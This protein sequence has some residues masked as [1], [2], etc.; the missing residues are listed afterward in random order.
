V[1]T[2]TRGK[3]NDEGSREDH[4][5]PFAHPERTW[6]VRVH[7]CLHANQVSEGSP[8]GVVARAVCVV[9]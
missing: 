5:N 2:A 1:T 3:H 6:I 4:T 7:P 8:D 9:A